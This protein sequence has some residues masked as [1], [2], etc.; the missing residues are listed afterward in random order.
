MKEPDSE[1]QVSAS[2]A[3]KPDFEA[4]TPISELVRGE[5]TRDAFFDTVLGLNSPATVKEIAD[6]AGHGVDA[7]R[8]YLTWFEQLGIVTQVTDSPATYERNQ[9]YLNWRRVQQLRDEH[10]METLLSYLET[11]R[12]REEEYAEQ[13]G[14]D[15]PDAVS[16]HTI[17]TERD[18]S[19]ESLWQD[20]SAWKT[21]RRRRSL[22]E[23]AI[24][25]ETS[26]T[27][28]RTAV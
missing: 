21:V 23:A 14:T 13:F 2:E 11:A 6:R 25:A 4:L 24:D 12:T 19:V 26:E 5:R 7:A 3:Q 8:E 17:A 10:S 9:A 28:Q 15:S 22:L 20:L 16:I 27:D 1:L 18:C